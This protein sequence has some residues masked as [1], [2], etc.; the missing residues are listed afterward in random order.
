[1]KT[2]LPS[3]KIGL[4]LLFVCSGC[5]YTL[6]EERMAHEVASDPDYRKKHAGTPAQF[7]SEQVSLARLEVF[8]VKEYT[9]PRY[10]RS[11]LKVANIARNV[12]RGMEWRH[13]VPHCKIPYLAKAPE[14]DGVI[15][16]DEWKDALEFRGE[17]LLDSD[18]AVQNSSAVWK[19]GY[20][21]DFLYFA[22]IFRDPAI[23]V[24]SDRTS[25]N[26]KAF[27]RGDCFEIF[28]RPDL[29]NPHYF[30]ML[31][32][33]KNEEWNMFHIHL[34]SGRWQIADEDFQAY[35]KKAVRYKD[36]ILTYETAIPFRILFSKW[37]FLGCR[38][39]DRFSFTLARCDRNGEEY[40][41]TVPFPLLYDVHNIYGFAE[42][43]LMPPR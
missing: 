29:K 25:N 2:L 4:L 11:V 21:R 15:D 17:Y 7:Y 24:Y 31:L 40:R 10:A 36:G 26:E 42:A 12:K 41:Q 3:W 38:A 33:P 34:D 27:Y 35:R 20:D 43:E 22:G 1:M 6:Q 9:L 32:N 39:G 13:P 14:I 16:K 23:T 37:S 19:I 5:S 8:A 30:E 18:K 28:I